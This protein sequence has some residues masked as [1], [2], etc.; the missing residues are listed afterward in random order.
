MISLIKGF[1]KYTTL[2][3]PITFYNNLV[4]DLDSN[5]RTIENET[6]TIKLLELITYTTSTRPKASDVKVGSV[7][8]N[9]T[10]NSPNFSDGTNWRDGAG[11]IV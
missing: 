3:N 6:N 1:K 2:S 5:F 4:K 7:F 9:T 11:T 8:F 10:T